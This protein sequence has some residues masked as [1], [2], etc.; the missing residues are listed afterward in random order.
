MKHKKEWKVKS[1]SSDKYYIV[2]ID[3]IGNYSCSCPYWKYK[4]KDCKHIEEIKLKGGIE[5]KK[6]E[7]VLAKV[8][9]PKLKDGAMFIPL[10]AIGDLH[11][12]ATIDYFMLKNGWSMADIIKIRHLRKDFSV[13]S[14]KEIIDTLGPKKYPENW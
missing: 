11:M 4:R 2:G 8:N 14:I 10:V 6:A 7:Y 13:R 12:E 5:V 1:Y 9:E 3:S